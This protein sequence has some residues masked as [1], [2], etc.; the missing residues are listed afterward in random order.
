MV[1]CMLKVFSKSSQTSPDHGQTVPKNRKGQAEF[2]EAGE[3]TVKNWAAAGRVA[4]DPAPFADPAA[5]VEWWERLRAGGH[6]KHRVPD[7]LLLAA[8]RWQ[9]GVPAASVPPASVPSASGPPAAMEDVPSVGPV[10][11]DLSQFSPDEN[12]SDAAALA[13]LNCQAQGH[14]LRAA[15]QSGDGSKIRMAQSA[16]EKAFDT[17][18]AAETSV[19]RIMAEQGRT[20]PREEIERRIVHLHAPMPKRL[21]ASLLTAYQRLP[22]P[23]PPHDEWKAITAEIVG[24]VCHDLIVSLAA[25]PD[26]A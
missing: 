21:R 15:L 2:Y 16:Y 4:R 3:K 24:E 20:V 5:M 11:L 26:Y 18:R 22:E 14:L 23:R 25:K 8:A 6:F 17:Y 1:A 13:K 7:N 12:F 10:A 9:S 19:G